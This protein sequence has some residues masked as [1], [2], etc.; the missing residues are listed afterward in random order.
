[1]RR[2]R[3]DA[4]PREESENVEEE[5]KEHEKSSKRG[6]RTAHHAEECKNK[7][8]RQSKTS[9]TVANRRA[10]AR[11][12]ATTTRPG[13][14]PVRPLGL[15]KHMQEVE[16]RTCGGGGGTQGHEKRAKT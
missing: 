11:P 10:S 8:R 1:M 14:A 5:V 6:G 13:Q 4:R 2:R 16:K 12:R 9:P 7:V 3:R 15:G